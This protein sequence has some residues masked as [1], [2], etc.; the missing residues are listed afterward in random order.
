MREPLQIKYHFARGLWV[1]VL[2]A[3]VALFVCR[4]E[5]VFEGLRL[6]YS[7]DQL[8]HFK[9]AASV[10]ANLL[11]GNF[12]PRV[13]MGVGEETGNPYHQFYSPATHLFMAAGGLFLNDPLLGAT[14]AIPLMMAV[15]FVFAFKLVG[16]LTRDVI[17]ALLGAFL[18]ALSP[19]AHVSR[20]SHGAVAEYCGIC[21][22]PMVV[23]ALTRAV[24][25]PTFARVTLG[26]LA[27]AL[28]WHVHILSSFLT[29][30]S[31]GT[32]GTL[33]LIRAGIARGRRAFRKILKRALVFLLA[34]AVALL[35]SAYY[36]LP[37]VAEAD[38]LIKHPFFKIYL[39][40]SSY[41]VPFLSLFS[42]TD[43]PFL[44][45]MEFTRARYQLGAPF[46]AGQ[47]A[48]IYLFWREWRSLWVYP[49][50]ALNLLILG[51]ILAPETLVGIPF[52]GDIQFSFRLLSY[53]QLGGL[54]A[55]ALSARHLARRWG[56]SGRARAFFALGIV[57][58]A[59]F[60]GAPYFAGR[61]FY[62]GFPRLLSFEQ[63]NREEFNRFSLFAYHRILPPGGKVGT[64][65]E[66]RIVPALPGS[67]ARV[68][69]FR[70][71]LAQESARVGWRG[72][73]VF[74]VLYY[75]RLQ[76]IEATLDGEPWTPK[77]DSFWREPTV[78]TRFKW[79]ANTGEHF[80]RLRE[81][82][83]KGLL[84]VKTTFRGSW[85]GN[86]VSLG[87]LASLTLLGIARG[88]G[89]GPWARPGAGAARRR[90]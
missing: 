73:A 40:L 79:L 35:L 6:V 49:L 29:L 45:P 46:W 13:A 53:Y 48:F 58:C 12:P 76:R 65:A 41:C 78:K 63:I 33:Q 56:F 3:F 62:P 84:R 54:L 71:D 77:A 23:L 25:R 15:G 50:I 75:P 59:F 66:S 11:E 44:M 5:E 72:E 80:L 90:V 83:E 1:W 8:N 4:A 85:L 27:V 89:L 87:A 7:P 88:A 68:R 18:F 38:L 55:L 34:V 36:L 43:F 82:P 16:Y 17:W 51:A 2:A 21:L 39:I 14:L 60:L 61:E 52:C 20:A 42:L 74:Q 32:L 57:A 64:L 30:A 24:A 22:A 26:A 10:R 70:L 31:L 9:L 81:L 69:R 19:Y 67:D 86:R 28:Q 37:I 47:I